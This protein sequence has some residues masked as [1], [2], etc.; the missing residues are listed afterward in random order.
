ML[1]RELLD[2][3]S[4]DFARRDGFENWASLWAWHAGHAEKSER[5]EGALVRQVIAWRLLDAEQTAALDAG[6]ARL[7]EVA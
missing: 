1:A 3:E 4:D 2:A 5:R 6:V 7:D